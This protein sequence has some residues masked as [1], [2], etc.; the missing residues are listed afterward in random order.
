MHNSL[1]LNNGIFNNLPIYSN[2]SLFSGVAYTDWSWGGLFLDMDNDG[3][4]DLF[5]TNGVLKDINNRDI[6]DE[7]K[8]ILDIFNNCK[9][10]KIEY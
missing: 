6:L 3:Y 2:I 9:L 4:K 5:V 1:Q 10:N 7:S 8:K